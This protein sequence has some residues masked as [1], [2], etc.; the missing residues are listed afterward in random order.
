MSSGA[1]MNSGRKIVRDT[2]YST[3]LP[4]GHPTAHNQTAN[5]NQGAAVVPP[6]AA[7]V[8]PTPSAAITGEAA[9]A[10]YNK[11]FVDDL[12]EVIKIAIRD[13]HRDDAQE[14]DKTTSGNN[15]AIPEASR[16]QDKTTSQEAS[17]KQDKTTSQKDVR[18]KGKVAIRKVR[19]EKR[20]QP[21]QTVTEHLSQFSSQYTIA[22]S[23]MIVLFFLRTS[24]NDTVAIFKPW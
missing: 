7:S 14:Q 10:L 15:V 4:I 12:R 16:K 22:S 20:A 21:Y 23:A 9:H 13:T 3:Y 6:A 1:E 5:G 24:P 18:R 11:A 19:P 2:P 17:R 8:P